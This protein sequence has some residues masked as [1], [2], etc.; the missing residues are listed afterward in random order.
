MPYKIVQT[1]TVG[2]YT[3]VEIQTEDGIKA[4][5]ISRRAQGDE[6]RPDVGVSIATGRA[7]KAAHVKA[8]NKKLQNPL[9]G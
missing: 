5:G 9:M 8:N 2:R 6:H 7:T 4:V 3:L 1:V